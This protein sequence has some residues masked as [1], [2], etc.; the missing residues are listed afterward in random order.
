M[1]A[2][3]L[4]IIVWVMTPCGLVGQH[5]YCKQTCYFHL[6]G[7]NEWKMSAVTLSGENYFDVGHSEPR[8]GDRRQLLSDETRKLNRDYKNVTHRIRERN[9]RIWMFYF[10]DSERP[11][12]N[13]EY[14]LYLWIPIFHY[15]VSES[16]SFLST[17]SQW[18]L[19]QTLKLF[20]SQICFN[21][22]LAYTFKSSKLSFPLL[23]FFLF[24]T[25]SMP[26]S[27]ILLVLLVAAH[28]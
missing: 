23:F 27:L 7:W 9:C 3:V 5:Q 22:I 21:I 16:V 6:R 28:F 18:T 10:S 2:S 12:D 14:F 19:I 11:L 13:V 17:Y 4:A 26:F 1:A 24:Y 25:I 20:L 8:E 15:H